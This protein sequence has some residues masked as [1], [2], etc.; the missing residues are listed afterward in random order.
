MKDN[1]KKSKNEK[2]NRLKGLI[3][4]SKKIEKIKNIAKVNNTNTK[5]KIHKALKN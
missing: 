4:K 2:K 3:C 1:V 5:V